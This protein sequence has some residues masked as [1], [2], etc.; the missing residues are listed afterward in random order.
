MRKLVISFLLSLSMQNSANA[1][2]IDQSVA[3][4]MEEAHRAMQERIQMMEKMQQELMGQMGTHGSS[5]STSSSMSYQWKKTESGAVFEFKFDPKREQE[6]NITIEGPVISIEQ[7]SSR[8][9]KS[10]ATSAYFYSNSTQTIA[11]PSHLDHEKPRFEKKEGKILIYFKK[12]K[13][14]QEGVI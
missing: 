7:S 2:S 1:Q 14:M 10:K 11:I 8:D 6:F 13:G 3:D 4:L 12:K 9:S 5:F